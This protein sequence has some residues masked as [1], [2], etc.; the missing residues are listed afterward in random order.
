MIFTRKV[1]GINSISEARNLFRHDFL[2]R[3]SFV[4][5]RAL[6]VLPLAFGI[7]F[8]A[9]S[10]S[11]MTF[12]A[13]YCGTGTRTFTRSWDPKYETPTATCVAEGTRF[14]AELRADGIAIIH[15]YYPT[16]APN[17]R[18]ECVSEGSEG[19]RQTLQGTHD[20]KGSF[21]I[22]VYNYITDE[23][24]PYIEGSFNETSLTSNYTHYAASSASEEWVT[25]D[26]HLDRMDEELW[27]PRAWV[28]CMTNPL[29]LTYPVGKSPR[30]FT[31][32]W[33]FG[34]RCVAYRGEEEIDCSDSVMWSGS[35]EFHP[36]M[37]RRSTP[38]FHGEGANTID[39]SVEVD[40]KRYEKSFTVEAVSPYAYARVTDIAKAICAHGC[41]KC[42][43][44]VQ[45]PIITGS[46]DVSIDG[47]PAA[48]VGDY[49]IHIACCSM[50]MYTIASGDETVLINGRPAA[51]KGDATTHCGGSGNI[52]SGSATYDP[53][54]HA[55]KLPALELANARESRYPRWLSEDARQLFALDLII[56]MCY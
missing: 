22:E 24:V 39:L 16:S 44:A 20:S 51:R 3:L 36:N 7:I 14:Q 48:R 8:V 52:I 35:G 41:P 38:N 12:P 21:R 18:G 1:L 10:V 34:A 50:N 32:G 43:H 11:A 6:N 19:E 56:C 4:P 30:V 5:L 54:A 25:F 26:L 47:L 42:P 46:Q 55:I 49:G 37:G 29:E 28:P 23:N 15:M 9:L 31:K 13:Y 53:A 33:P 2:K 27:D 17:I 45:G 40:G